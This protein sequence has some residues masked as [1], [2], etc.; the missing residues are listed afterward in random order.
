MIEQFCIKHVNDKNSVFIV[1]QLYT[2]IFKLLM[3][4]YQDIKMNKLMTEYFCVI[5]SF[6]LRVFLNYV[7][8]H[9]KK[10]GVRYKVVKVFG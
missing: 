4:L 5:V 1:V 10:W 6:F 8:V 2:D 3:F 7:D 9:V